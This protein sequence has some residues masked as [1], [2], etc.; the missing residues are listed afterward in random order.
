MSQKINP[1]E[2]FVY[3]F[4]AI[5]ATLAG[6]DLPWLD[7]LRRSGIGQFED[8]GLPGPKVE[9]WKYTLLRPL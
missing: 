4:E 8:I 9:S 5:R 2:N 6:N 3:G 7:S 1:V